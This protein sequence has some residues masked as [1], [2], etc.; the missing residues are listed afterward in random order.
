[1]R[2]SSTDISEINCVVNDLASRFPAIEGEIDLFERGAKV[3]AST[4][5]LRREITGIN[6][7]KRF[8]PYGDSFSFA[9]K[10]NAVLNDIGEKV[11]PDYPQEALALIAMFIETD[12]RLVGQ[13]DDSAG[14]MGDSYRKA[15]EMFAKASKAAGYPLRAHKVFFRLISKSDYGTRDMLFDLAP[16]ILS[17]TGLRVLIDQWTKRRQGVSFEELNLRLGQ[18]AASVGDSMLYE[19]CCLQGR[20]PNSHPLL[21]FHVVRC[22]LK[23]GNPKEA[24]RV[25][26]QRDLGDWVI[27]ERNELLARTYVDLGEPEKAQEVML[28]QF[29]VSCCPKEAEKLLKT[30]PEEERASTICRLN[31]L[32]DESETDATAKAHYFTEMSEFNSAE[33]IIIGNQGSFNGDRY[34]MLLAIAEPLEDDHPV[35]AS[36]LYRATMESILRRAISKNYPHAVRYYEKLSDLNRRIEDW[37]G[38]QKHSA[39]WK[40]I[41]IKHDKK[42][43]FW[44]R[45]R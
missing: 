13:G 9:K 21:A 15:C 36:I 8:I 7:Q 6:R 4:T 12:G 30:L 42:S 28:G 40:E 24:L 23:S 1:M 14:E 10:L 45:I 44:R 20:D 33:D 39:Y 5:A 27:S 38:V 31:K 26:P 35:G 18:I 29:R 32:V 3:C 34:W 17:P 43:A 22:H 25:I 11:L 19:Q 41:E 2:D 37:K 16:N